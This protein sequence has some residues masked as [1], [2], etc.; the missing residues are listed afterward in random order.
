MG[1]LLV[2]AVARS[3]RALRVQRGLTQEDLADLASLDRTYISGVERAVRNITLQS[4]EQIVFALDVELPK[5]LEKIAEQI[6][7]LSNK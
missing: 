6:N 1:D 3:V 2:R 4:L 5:F 7:E